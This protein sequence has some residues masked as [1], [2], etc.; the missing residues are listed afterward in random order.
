MYCP[1][2]SHDNRAERRFCADCGAALAVPCAACGA[3]NEPGEKFCGDCGASL[4]GPSALPPAAL[5][6]APA[7][8]PDL[9][10]AVATASRP[11]PTP[12]RRRHRLAAVDWLLIGTL[13]PVC[14]FGFVMTVVHGV[15]GDF[16]VAPFWV[17]SAPDEQSYPMVD[18]LLSSPGASASSLEVGDRLLR[19]EGSDFRGVSFA[20]FLL[21]ASRAARAGARSLLLTIERGSTRTDVRVPLVP[22]YS[23]PGFTWWAPLPLIVGIV[24]T[25]LLLLVR[26]DRKSVV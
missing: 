3:A 12:P 23:P 10:P 24:G 7:V 20:G 14:V 4:R 22:G 8:L 6:P 26:A 21:R 5:P 19:L 2:C 13:L 18:R 11:P 9:A 25:A 15:R 1:S 17:S 16:V